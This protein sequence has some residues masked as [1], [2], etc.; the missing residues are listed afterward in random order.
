[1]RIGITT[2]EEGVVG[3]DSVIVDVVDISAL[4]FVGDPF[5]LSDVDF[6]FFVVFGVEG[7]EIC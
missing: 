2:G 7:G 1:M 6:P 4:G 5:L 3:L